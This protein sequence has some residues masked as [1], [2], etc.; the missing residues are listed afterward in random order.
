M[1]IYGKSLSD[2]K[3][4]TFFE[5]PKLDFIGP[6]NDRN[7]AVYIDVPTTDGKTESRWNC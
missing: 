7:N 2:S 1:K 6:L 5:S 3:F 4:M